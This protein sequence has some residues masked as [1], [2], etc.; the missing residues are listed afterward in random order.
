M[1][2]L[3]VEH[4]QEYQTVWNGNDGTLVMYQSEIPYDVPVQEVWMS[5]NGQRPGYSSIYVDENVDTFSATA[6]GIYLYNRVATIRLESAMEMPRTDNTHVHNI[7]TVMLT[8]NPGM[9]HIINDDGDA[10]L[11]PGATAILKDY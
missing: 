3:M 10:V 4:F 11:T 1:Y 6:L 5:H 9:V 8:G 7:I 2:A